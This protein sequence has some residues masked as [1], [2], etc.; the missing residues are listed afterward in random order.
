MG[1]HNDGSPVAI[2]K[3][4]VDLK[5]R[6][7]EPF[8]H[9]NLEGWRHLARWLWE[10]PARAGAPHGSSAAHHGRWRVIRRCVS[11]ARPDQE[12]PADGAGSLAL[13]PGGWRFRIYFL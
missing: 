9:D 1:R 7:L 12:Q 13:P 5:G 4:A 11:L 6:A 3:A 8:R 10:T 2:P